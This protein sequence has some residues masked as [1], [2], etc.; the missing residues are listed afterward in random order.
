MI[1]LNQQQRDRETAVA[2][3]M[4]DLIVEN[5]RSTTE[6]VPHAI[7]AHFFGLACEEA[8]FLPD[9]GSARRILHLVSGKLSERRRVADRLNE[10][11]L[12][13]TEDLLELQR[14]ARDA[15]RARR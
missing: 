9:E 11:L 2:Q 4:T 1:L 7:L 10:F 6:M 13:S 14:T 12:T 8:S 5:C 3:R 15:K